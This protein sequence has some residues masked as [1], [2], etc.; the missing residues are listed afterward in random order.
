MVTPLC[1]CVCTRAYEVKTVIN[2]V[3]IVYTP[4]WNEFFF[5]HIFN[6]MRELRIRHLNL[7]Q[8]YFKCAEKML[9]LMTPFDGLTMF[10]FVTFRINQY[11]LNMTMNGKSKLWQFNHNISSNYT[12]IVCKYIAHNGMFFAFFCFAFGQSIKNI[13]SENLQMETKRTTLHNF[14]Y[15]FCTFT[16]EL[17]NY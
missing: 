8:I 14:I 12:L 1:I 15:S 17:H 16:N 5:L 10:Y 2:N 9:W 6:S 13:K 11:G 3:K 7:D 4:H